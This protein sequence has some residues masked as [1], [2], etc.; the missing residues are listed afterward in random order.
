MTAHIQNAFEAGGVDG[1]VLFGA[2]AGAFAPA[3]T[4]NDAAEESAFGRES[5]LTFKGAVCASEATEAT[6]RDVALVV[7][8]ASR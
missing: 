4:K 8:H 6:D 3:T 7:V 5:Q 1:E 2:D